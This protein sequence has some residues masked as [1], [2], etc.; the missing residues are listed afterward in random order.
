MSPTVSKTRLGAFQLHS[1]E[2]IVEIIGLTA[3]LARSICKAS[4]LSA[5]KAAQGGNLLPTVAARNAVMNAM[6][7]ITRRKDR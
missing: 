4:A 3:P 1:E 2:R 5:D 6:A 7:S